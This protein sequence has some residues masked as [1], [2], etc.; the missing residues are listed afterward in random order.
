MARLWPDLGPEDGANNWPR[1]VSTGS[2]RRTKG[3]P[4]WLLVLCL[5]GLLLTETIARTHSAAAYRLVCAPQLYAAQHGTL[6]PSPTQRHVAS[7]APLVPCR[8]GRRAGRGAAGCFS[9][10]RV[11]FHTPAQARAPPRQPR[12]SRHTGQF[13]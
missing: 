9:P 8:P 6:R 1:T 7:G 10:P 12:C 4:R 11:W 3:T 2:C 5:A 13:R